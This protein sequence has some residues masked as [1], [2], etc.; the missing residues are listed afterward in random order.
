[1]KKPTKKLLLVFSAGCAGGL[2]NSITVWLFGLL[3][4]TTLLGVS[5]SP[6]LTPEWLYPRIVW[7]GIWGILFL[8]PCLRGNH[9]LR[10]AL[11]SLGPTLV[12]LFIIFPFK[13]N[14]GIMGV[15][16]GTLTPFLVV[17]FNL[18]WGIKAAILLKI[19]E[20]NH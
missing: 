14:K 19:A 4:I 18:V 2:A 1:M 10:G 9:L 13:A 15:D 5:I 11:F 3:G 8:L 6:A 16:L 12:Q 7:G 20:E 17:F